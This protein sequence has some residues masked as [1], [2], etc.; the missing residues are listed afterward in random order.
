[1]TGIRSIR[2]GFCR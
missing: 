1:M 2:Q